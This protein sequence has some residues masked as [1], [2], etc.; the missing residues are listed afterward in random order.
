MS[1]HARSITTNLKF[2][3][4][5]QHKKLHR[6][7]RYFQYRD[8]KVQHIPQYDRF[9]KHINRWVDCGLGRQH[10][11]ILNRVNRLSTDTLKRNVGSRLM[12]IGP[13]VTLMHAIP[14]ERRVDILNE[15]TEKTMELW[16]DHMNLPTP[17]YSYIVHESQ[18][19][20]HRPDGRLK[21]EPQSKS[22]LHTHVVFAPTVQGI[23]HDREGYKVYDK[24]I[25]QLHEAGR[26][27]LQEIWERE[28]GVER[29]AELQAE[30]N[31]RDLRQRQLDLQQTFKL[32]KQLSP[33]LL[34]PTFELNPLD[35]GLDRQ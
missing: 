34:E 29:F 5:E 11:D 18:P 33:T 1:V 20:Q 2:T 23:E 14:Y 17:E 24:Q 8:N 6:L 31:E 16:F 35:E 7:L 28:L 21:D 22:Y 27:A 12:V 4:Q 25:H 15:L 10:Q 13:E 26:E 19:A 3:Y 32:D 9:G 30:L